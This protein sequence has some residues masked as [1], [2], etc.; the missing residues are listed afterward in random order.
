MKICEL[1]K[2]SR[3]LNVG[4]RIQQMVTKRK[5]APAIAVKEKANVYADYGHS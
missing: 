3:M 2:G 5:T 4:I 1:K